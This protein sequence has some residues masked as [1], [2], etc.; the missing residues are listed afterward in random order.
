MPK[1][2]RYRAIDHTADLG[3][4]VWGRTLPELYVHAAE[5]MCALL[6]DLPAVEP[7]QE[8]FIS[9]AGYDREEVL[10]DWLR[11][12][13]YLAEAEEFLPCRFEVLELDETHLRARVD[14]EPFD[15]DRHGWRSGI[16]AATY[17]DLH[18]VQTPGEGW[19][20]QIIFDT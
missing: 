8:R 9:A 12:L 17:H 7:R 16:K 4:Q 5:G 14:G 2:R 3:L 6:F 13:L 11:E 18:I 10:V 1:P 20:V 19:M 15:P